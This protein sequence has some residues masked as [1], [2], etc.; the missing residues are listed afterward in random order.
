MNITTNE[1]TGLLL[2]P[3]ASNLA[4]NA[5][6][7]VN[8][9]GLVFIPFVIV[10][11]KA[12]FEA[13]S[14]GLDEGSPAVL[15]IKLTERFFYGYLLV[16]VVVLMP[17]NTPINVTHT[18]YAC[19]KKPSI[20]SESFANSTGA[21]NDALNAM[22][23]Q[24]TKSPSLWVGLLHQISTGMTETA[25]SQISC[26]SGATA[27][28]ITSIL[29]FAK[30]TSESVYKSI[31]Y[32]HN[33]CYLV[34]KNLAHD[35]I[36]TGKTL[37]HPTDNKYAWSFKRPSFAPNAGLIEGVYDGY[38]IH[39]ENKGTLTMEV[40]SIWFDKTKPVGKH[41]NCSAMANSLYNKIQ[42]DLT[43]DS[44]YNDDLAALSSFLNMF[45]NAS[46]TEI[47]HDMTVNVY[48]NVVNGVITANKEEAA[49][50]QAERLK[51][52]GFGTSII[53]KKALEQA[54]DTESFAQK[55][56]STVVSIGAIKQTIFE[57][58]KAKAVVVILP[59][60]ITVF[61]AVL[62]AA[63]PALIVLSGG[64]AK[65]IFHW[66]LF[67]FSITFSAFFLNV[68]IQLESLLLS[69]ANYSSSLLA[70]TM[71]NDSAGV[72]NAYLVS[73][74]AATFVYLIPVIWVMLVQIIGNISASSFMNAVAGGAMVGDAGAK[75]TTGAIEKTVEKSIGG[76]DDNK[77]TDKG[78]GQKQTRGSRS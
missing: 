33:K 9:L 11:I 57:T 70:H 48:E 72:E 1:I 66:S 58:A 41:Q 24:Q 12:T 30:P 63:L 46:P 44:S 6:D 59:M 10:M 13:R 28:E 35:A 17:T 67:Y 39:G 56:F 20:L 62:I 36:S 77:G 75:A 47:R 71:N 42:D 38:Y 8:Q 16:I 45:N 52:W 14:E 25:T 76:K 53:P 69:L 78:T 49:F 19:A 32:F 74:A 3:F 7:L 51:S 2:L 4:D 18:Q 26:S 22:G 43:T 31:E 61:Q 68:G 23:L 34:A 55:Y 40:P 5:W 27:Q 50:K 21:A 37:I 54:E 29:K 65:F 15:A 64:S 60:L 73:A